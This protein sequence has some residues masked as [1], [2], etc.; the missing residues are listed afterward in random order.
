M[1]MLYP[2]R[3]SFRVHVTFFPCVGWFQVSCSE[4]ARPA[5]AVW[6]CRNVAAFTALCS[7]FT[8][9]ARVG[10]RSSESSVCEALMFPFVIKI[11]ISVV[12]HVLRASDDMYYQCHNCSLILRVN[13]MQNIFSCV[14]T[15]VLRV[16]YIFLFYL[17]KSLLRYKMYTSAQG[18]ALATYY[19][20]GNYLVCFLHMRL[21]YLQILWASTLSCMCITIQ[22][23][24]I[25][26]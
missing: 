20:R 12:R 22:K 1:Q 18:L 13:S 7:C 2:Y 9:S 23:E 16:K 19:K 4:K 8:P 25:H 14:C 17:R 10:F 26:T 11:Y 21:L 24:L 15:R 3:I 5:R 6:A